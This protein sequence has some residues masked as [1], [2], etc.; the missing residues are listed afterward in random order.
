MI[1]TKTKQHG[2]QEKEKDRK[3]TD[4]NWWKKGFPNINDCVIAFEKEIDQSKD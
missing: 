2:L 3:V 4:P 1:T